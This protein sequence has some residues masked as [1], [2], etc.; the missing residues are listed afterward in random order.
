MNLKILTTTNNLIIQS[1]YVQY[2]VELVQVLVTVQYRKMK[3][4]NCTGNPIFKNYTANTEI[5]LKNLG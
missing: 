4:Y 5:M 1:N 3:M 2:H